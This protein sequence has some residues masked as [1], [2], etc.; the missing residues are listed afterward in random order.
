MRRG[1]LGRAVIPA[2][3]DEAGRGQSGATPHRH[4]IELI[5][6]ATR[7]RVTLVCGP[8]ESGKTLACS[9]W[10]ARQL[11]SLVV[12]LSLSADDDQ[13]MF[14]ARVHHGLLRAAAAPLDALQLLAEASAP[15]FPLRLAEAAR[16]FARPVVII[17]DNAHAATS[18]LVLTG[19]DTLLQAAPSSLRMVLAGRDRPR[20][21][22]LT[23][24]QAVGDVSIIGPADLGLRARAGRP[25]GE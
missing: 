17:I 11:G 2:L 23:R 5:E 15:E 8:A 6:R 4:L 7:R 12:W 19:L 20:L 24:L 10:A 22:Q 9:L 1:A 13:A 3:A 14:W 18:S 25:D 16:S 21:R